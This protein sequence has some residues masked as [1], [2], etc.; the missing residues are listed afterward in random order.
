MEWD[1]EINK[2]KGFRN[3]EDKREQYMAR[4]IIRLAKENKRIL[5]VLDIQRTKGIVTKIKNLAT[6]M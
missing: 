6:S 3:L 1:A 4:E 5:C 2:L